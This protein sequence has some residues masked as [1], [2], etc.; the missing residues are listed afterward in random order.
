MPIARSAFLTALRT[1]QAIYQRSGGLLGHRL[2]M[3]M[4]TLLLRTTGAKSGAARTNALVYAKDGDRWIVV[5]SNGGAPR[6]SAWLHN[7]RAQPRAEVQVGRR[8]TAVEAHEVRR[9]EP[10]F[11]R[12]WAAAN[13]ANHGTYDKY[14]AKTERQIPVVVL[15][16][17]G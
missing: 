15:V 8:R 2:F 9:G 13:R 12:F 7:L 16:P 3:G 17:V 1:H 11:E 5:P 14:Q 10:D 6:H 4:P